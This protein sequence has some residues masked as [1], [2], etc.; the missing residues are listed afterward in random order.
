MRLAPL[1][2]V[3]PSV[4]PTAAVVWPCAN[5]HRHAYAPTA[6]A[7]TTAHRLRTTCAAAAAAQDGPDNGANTERL[8]AL[9]RQHT[10]AGDL[11]S[12]VYQFEQAASQAPRS[13][14]CQ[15][16]L[17]RALV[18]LGR[19]QE[20]FNCLVAAFGIDSLCPGVKDGFREYYRAEIEADPNNIDLHEGLAA[21]CVDS[22][23]PEEA[24]ALYRR[25]LG[26]HAAASAEGGGRTPSFSSSDPS[27]AGHLSSK[28]ATEAA[29]AARKDRWSVA[30]FKCNASLCQWDDWNGE[31]LTLRTAVRRRER[32]RRGR[33]RGGGVGGR[34]SSV[35][36]DGDL[37]HRLLLGY[38]DDDF[39]RLVPRDKQQ[40]QGNNVGDSDNGGVNGDAG[41]GPSRPA[42]H[43]FDSL[44]APLSIGDCLAVAQQQTSGVLS[45]ARGGNSGPRGRDEEK[46]ILGE[47]GVG[48]VQ[49]QSLR[50]F[51]SGFSSPSSSPL[52]RDER[53][54]V[55]LGYVSGDLMGTH[56]LTHLMQSTFGMH[57]RDSFEVFLYA[58]NPDD[59]SAP[60]RRM[61]RE[62]ENFRDL[63]MMTAGEAAAAI[64]DDGVGVLV[65]L[66]GYAGTV[67]SADIFALRPAAVAVSYMGFPGTMGS[68]EMVDYILAD[69]VVVPPELRR[70]YSEKVLD[71]PHCYFVNDYRQSERGVIDSP[72]P[73]RADHGLSL[74][75][76]PPWPLP[77]ATEEDKEGGGILTAAAAASGA[78]PLV[79]DGRDYG[80][81]GRSRRATHRRRDG[82]GPGGGH[83]G[84]RAAAW[85]PVP[86]RWRRGG[87]RGTMKEQGA[88]ENVSREREGEGDGRRVVLCNFNRLHKLDP[89]T[90][91]AWMEVLR[92]VPGTVLWLIDGGETARTNLLRQARLAGVDEWRVV[93]AP[94]VGKEE[95]LQRLRLADL[96]VDTP[97]Y[98]AHTVGCDALWAGVPMVTLRGAKMASRVG[99]SLVEAAGMP[100]LVTDS[101]EEYTQLVL[102]LA[103]DN[104][105]RGDLRQKLERA[106]LTCPLFDTRRWVRDAEDVLRQAWERHEA[107]LP[108]AHC[109]RH[110]VSVEGAER[111]GGGEGGCS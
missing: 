57:D 55:R 28:E 66:G 46:R 34:L 1:Y 104:E 62:V 69:A 52:L 95:H 86:G 27:A 3:P 16:E 101:L 37:V 105:R 110:R 85:S 78:A 19:G 38:E 99:A 2:L 32:R 70:F 17:G 42:L 111:R 45:E 53:G 96:F 71:M 74:P 108:P 54:R 22:G 100:E 23:N 68:S 50:Q 82:G 18:R 83:N 8:L 81:G 40:R 7:T 44:S 51:H 6:R 84:E 103:R 80:V 56:P 31:A 11:E 109:S 25:C 93:F 91:G 41:A 4:A 12:A 106:R 63:S 13:A 47:E 107:G 58:L 67:K 24:A 75:P 73:E 20:G 30:L 65:N 14:V 89:H 35:E 94:L 26:L 87:G 77:P 48:G 98:N 15:T 97:L 59:G 9:G 102:A 36:D 49:G 10:Q 88:L 21:L 5:N 64:A 79:R 60:R 39:E 92:T 33:T 76:P 29:A 61:E 43:P 72:A 90:F